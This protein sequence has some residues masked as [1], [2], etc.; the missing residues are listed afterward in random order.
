MIERTVTVKSAEFKDT[1][2]GRRQYLS[3]VLVGEGGK[4]SKQ[5]VF[6]PHL[7]K[8][9]QDA[10][11]NNWPLI[12]KLEK[13]GNFWNI[14]EAE[15]ST[16]TKVSPDGERPREIEPDKKAD[17]IMLAVAFKGAIDLETHQVPEAE[18]NTKR[19]L[20]TTTILLAGLNLLRGKKE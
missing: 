10:L 14:K 3:A 7:Q 1:S 20:K 9:I 19:V 2:D 6:D 15:F 8:V 13:E 11:E 16:E 17:D 5:S 18:P 12:V 4:E